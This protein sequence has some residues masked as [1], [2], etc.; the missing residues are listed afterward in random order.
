MESDPSGQLA[1]LVSELDAAEQAGE[2]VYIIG[3]M[4]MGLDDALHDGSNYFNQIVDRYSATIAALFFA[5]HMLTSS[6]SPIPTTPTL[7]SATLSKS[8][9]SPLP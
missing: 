8:R 2:N 9:I 1:W 7:A 4:A 5:T 3:H 6:R